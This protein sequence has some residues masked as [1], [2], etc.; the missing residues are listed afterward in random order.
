MIDRG[1]LF[2]GF[3]DDDPIPQCAEQ[4]LPLGARLAGVGAPARVVVAIAA[5]PGK[6]ELLRTAAER[7]AQVL[8][9]RA[10]AQDRAFQCVPPEFAGAADAVADDED[11]RR[12]LVAFEDR[13]CA[14]R[15]SA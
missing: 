15:L 6:R 7:K 11:R 1:I 14:V 3:E 2:G 4:L 9:Q 12:D 8:G 10:A 13:Q 5:A